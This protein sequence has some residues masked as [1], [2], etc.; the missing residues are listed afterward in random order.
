M[1]KKNNKKN[2][3]RNKNKIANKNKIEKIIEINFKKSLQTK[4][5]LKKTNNKN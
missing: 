3:I 4:T 1:K 5:T 2:K